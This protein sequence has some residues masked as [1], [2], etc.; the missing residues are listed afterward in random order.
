ME[1]Q[2]QLALIQ[3]SIVWH[4]SAKNMDMYTTKIKQVK[5][6]VDLV[7]L[8][9]MCTTGFSMEPHFIAETM[10]GDT[11]TWLKAMAAMKQAVIAGS[12]IIKDGESFFNRFIFAFPSG[13]LKWYDK[14]HLF[15]LAKEHEVY[16]QGSER[17]VVAIKG[18]K[19][20]PMICYDL[21][22]PVWSRNTEDFDV[23]I[24]V[25]N[26]PKP[27]IE[28]WDALL[29]ARA[30][31]NMCYSVGVN[32]VGSDDNQLEYVGHTGAYDYLG[33][34]MTP[35]AHEVET[36]MDVTLDRDRM[37]MAREKLNFLSDRDSFKLS[38]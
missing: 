11:V 33:K 7:V 37:A 36:T 25:A 18:W 27:R 32:R 12:F 6:G 38:Y 16:E 23:L 4:N 20:C 28:A 35:A 21:R 9:E 1:A 2:L 17:I 14:R 24:Y 19:I 26:W 30:I 29:K 34:R 31:E 22:F 8:P 10:T 15:S 5:E 3:T 13:E